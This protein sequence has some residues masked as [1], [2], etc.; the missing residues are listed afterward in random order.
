MNLIVAVDEK[1]GIGKDNKLL[2]NIP[3]DLAFFREK[4]LG[5]VV[6]MGRST[7]ESLP[8]GKPL[9]NRTNIVLT[10]KKDFEIEGA[11]VVH[12]RE[13][14]MEE[15]NK[16]PSEDVL[17]IGGGSVYNEL[18]ENCDVL[19]ITKIYEDLDADTFIKN[20]DKLPQFKVFDVS[21]MIEEN[22]HKF[23]WIEYRRVRLKGKY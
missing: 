15:V 2:C 7:L 9:K 1:W 12:D 20:A 5:K 6:V 19:Y 4:T 23:Q 11:T 17:I 22:G 16:Y 14:L 21:E 8:N 10:R 18:M 13:E 3:K